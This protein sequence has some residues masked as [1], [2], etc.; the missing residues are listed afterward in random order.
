MLHYTRV[1]R[2]DKDKI[3]L[4]L[5]LFVSYKVSWIWPLSLNLKHF[6]FL[7]TDKW[8]WQAGVLHF[9]RIERLAK[10]NHDSLMG[11]F[12]S[13][14]ENELLWIWP[15]GSHSQHFISS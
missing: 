6:I 11:P 10:D 7:V 1:E 3:D 8:V 5:G 15:L 12:V 9:T 13:Y 4:L 14:K 2:L